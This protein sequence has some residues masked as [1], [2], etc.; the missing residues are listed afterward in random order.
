LIAV[1]W[2]GGI[3]ARAQM[4][5]MNAGPDSGFAQIDFAQMYLDQM[6]RESKVSEKQRIQ[7]KKLIDTGVVSALDLAAPGKAVDEFNRASALLRA[8][9]SKEAIKHLQKAI[10]DYPKFVSAYV[11]LGLAYIDEEDNGRAKSELEAAAKLDN[12]FPGPFLNLGLLALSMKDFAAGQTDLEQAA[13]LRPTDAKILSDLAYAQNGNHQY[14]QAEET[15]Q[16]VHRLEHKGM[17]NVHFTAASAAAS[18]RDYETMQRELDLF[19][20]EDP[21]NAYAPIARQNLA[22]LVRNKNATIAAAGP[23]PL[24]ATN[25]SA[26]EHLQTFP[27][28]DRLKAQLNAAGD[29][30]DAAVCDEC[31]TMDEANAATP[32]GGGSIAFNAPPGISARAGGAWTIRTSVD[33]VALFFE[34]SSHGRTVNDLELSDIK[35]RDADK[36]PEQILQF[37]PQSKLPLRLALLV[38]TSGSVHERF[39]F[40]KHAAARFVEKVLNPASDL[41][42]IAGFALE[43][44][45]TEDFS[46]DTGELGKGIE[47]L[48]EGGGTA[49][50][51]AVL[52]TCRKLAAYPDGERVAR[53]LVVLTDG[54]DNSSHSTLKQSIQAAERTGVTIYTVSTAE[55]IGRKTD[56]DKMLELLAERSGGEAMFPGDMLT[57]NKSL[58][59]LRDVIRSR[60]FVAYKPAGF[61]PDGS[62]RMINIIAE[63]DGKRLQVR[64]RKGYRARLE[65]GPN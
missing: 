35:I 3:F 15:A 47:K 53:V 11:A 62:Y 41:G 38:D 30:S 2:C 1:F 5:F 33:Q 17:A 63:K 43:P 59:K 6:N 50:F 58:D 46:S 39:S 40:E 32:N 28:S 26:S 24:K 10:D 42:F 34:V 23:G 12:K 57:L 27:N 4:P 9:N 25:V 45:V 21:T 51:D 13:S 36:T 7:N 52:F 56:A 65:S 54:E 16:R 20:S 55:E 37:A 49:L 31:S 48:T 19:L 18:L 64:A 29:E 14:K 44:T 22:A 8:Q 61:K 60:Y